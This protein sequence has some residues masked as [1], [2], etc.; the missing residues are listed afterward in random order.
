MKVTIKSDEEWYCIACGKFYEI[1][2]ITCDR[3][4]NENTIEEGDW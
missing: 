2:Q 4:L 1:H 3:C